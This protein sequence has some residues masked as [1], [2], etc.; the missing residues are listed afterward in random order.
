MYGIISDWL[1][2]EDCP[3]GNVS[4]WVVGL[5]LHLAAPL[6]REEEVVV[7]PVVGVLFAYSFTISAPFI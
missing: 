5:A 2:R 1:E 7:E 3:V 6:S 4:R